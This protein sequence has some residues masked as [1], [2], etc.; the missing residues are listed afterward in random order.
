[1]NRFGLFALGGYGIAVPLEQLERVLQGTEL[2]LLPRLPETVCAVLVVDGQ[3]VPLL[4]IGAFL[5]WGTAS[6][7]SRG[8]QVVINSECGAV[9]LAVDSGGR[10]SAAHKGDILSLPADELTPG[11]SRQFIYQ[12]RRYRI[13]DINYLA[14]EMTQVYWRN[15]SDTDGARRHQ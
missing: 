5:G 3:L 7:Q 13:L 14:I 12:D 15:P 6:P 8:Y 1:M 2:H 9:A 11:V 4:D 10:I